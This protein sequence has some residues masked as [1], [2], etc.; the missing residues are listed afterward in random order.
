MYFCILQT[1]DKLIVSFHGTLFLSPTKFYILLTKYDNGKF[2]KRKIASE[3]PNFFLHKS[4]HEKRF[5]SLS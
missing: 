2:N 5:A 3:R 4:S 1:Y